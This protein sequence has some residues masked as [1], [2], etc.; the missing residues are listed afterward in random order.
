MNTSAFYQYKNG[1]LAW[2]PYSAVLSHLYHYLCTR[3]S[4]AVNDIVDV[5]K[6]SLSPHPDRTR[7]RRA[8]S[9]P[10]IPPHTTMHRP[11]MPPSHRSLMKHCSRCRGAR[12]PLRP[13]AGRHQKNSPRK[14]GRGTLLN[15]YGSVETCLEPS[16]RRG[17]KHISPG[18]PRH[19]CSAPDHSPLTRI[20]KP[21][22]SSPR[23][24]PLNKY[25]SDG[26]LSARVARKHVFLHQH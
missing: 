14:C 20:Y 25:I 12:V 7:L 5:H 2:K 17:P 16:A 11:S 13:A 21:A 26:R 24:N 22:H 10:L 19:S 6:T 3:L 23:G 1:T 4:S 15:C 8:V 18:S 9:E